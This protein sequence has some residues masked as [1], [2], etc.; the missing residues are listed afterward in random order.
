MAR[1]SRRHSGEEV[2][3]PVEDRRSAYPA[4]TATEALAR[5][6]AP[7]VTQ[8]KPPPKHW[9]SQWHP[10]HSRLTRSQ[11]RRRPSPRPTATAVRSCGSP[12]ARVKRNTVHNFITTHWAKV[13]RKGGNRRCSACFLLVVAWLQ[14]VFKD[15]PEAAGA[16]KSQVQAILDGLAADGVESALRLQ[17]EMEPDAPRTPLAVASGRLAC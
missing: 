14:L 12:L 6:V 10:A 11:R 4:E 1:A 15:R 17:R 3:P 9:P 8:Q 13:F 5:P 16:Y 7:A 2:A